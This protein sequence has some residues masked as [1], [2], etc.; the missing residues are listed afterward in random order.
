MEV[1]LLT[2]LTTGLDGIEW[3]HLRSGEIATDTR[4]SEGWLVPESWRRR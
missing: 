4:W 1:E 3:L 2:F